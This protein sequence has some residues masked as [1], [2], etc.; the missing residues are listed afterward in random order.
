VTRDDERMAA[1]AESF[2]CLACVPGVRPWDPAALDAAAS[3]LSSGGA[4]AARFVL[5]VHNC[6]QRWRAGPFRLVD[7]LGAWD[8]E[9][10]AAWKAWAADPWSL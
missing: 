5:E 7:A 9:H 6:Y 4:H 3:N 10:R 1:L 2:P 8:A